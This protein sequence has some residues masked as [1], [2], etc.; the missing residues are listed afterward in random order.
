MS[1]MKDASAASPDD[2]AAM[3]EPGHGGPAPTL[4]KRAPGE[5]YLAPD[6]PGDGSLI[7]SAAPELRIYR[8]L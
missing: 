2:G 5:R 6:E 3:I 4:L 1:I 7:F 8:V